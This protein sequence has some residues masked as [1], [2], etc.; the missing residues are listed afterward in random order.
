MAYFGC[1]N[2]GLQEFDVKSGPKIR[3]IAQGHR[4][5]LNYNGHNGRKDTRKGDEIEAPQLHS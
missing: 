5:A 1:A 3:I 4:A 2:V